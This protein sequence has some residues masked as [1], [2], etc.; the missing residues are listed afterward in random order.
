MRGEFWRALKV[1][2]VTLVALIALVVGRERGLATLSG[3]RML[4][5]SPAQR[6]LCY[7]VDRAHQPEFRLSGAERGLRLVSHKVLGPAGSLGFDPSEN[8]EYALRLSLS[9]ASGREVWSTTVREESRQSKVA[10]FAGGWRLEGAY[11]E[12]RDQELSDARISTIELP[13]SVPVGAKLKV[14]ALNNAKLLLRSYA[15]FGTQRDELRR[16]LVSEPE[17]KLEGLSYRRVRDLNL[18]STR[19]ISEIKAS[20]RM[21]AS[22]R[23]K[24]KGAVVPVFVRPLPR[25][26]QESHLATGM[27][28]GGPW[29]RV[30]LVKGPGELEVEIVQDAPSSR[31]SCPDGTLHVQ[32]L[33][34]QNQAQSQRYALALESTRVGRQRLCRSG[35]VNLKLGAELEDLRLRWEPGDGASRQRAARL[36]VWA[37][38]GQVQLLT[39]E[40]WASDSVPREILDGPPL[41]IEMEKLGPQT[42][43]LLRYLVKA[44]QGDL[45]EL[46][47]SVRRAMGP[48]DHHEEP[49]SVQLSWS[50]VDQQSKVLSTGE[51]SFAAPFDSTSW[52]RTQRAIVPG[53][54]E[55]GEVS[56]MER[57]R[58]KVPRRA[59]WVE[60]R[61]SAKVLVR[62]STRLR[63]SQEV[64]P[65]DEIFARIPLGKMKWMWAPRAIRNWLGLRA[66][67][68]G[69]ADVVDVESQL[70]LKLAPPVRP[71]VGSAVYKTLE[72]AG[73]SRRQDVLESV[74][75]GRQSGGAL[76][77]ELHAQQEYQIQAS[78]SLR[79]PVQLL[80]DMGRP[81]ALSEREACALEVDGQVQ[82]LRCPILRGSQT[83][84]QLE[85]GS[86]QI[87]WRGAPQGARIW[88]NQ[89]ARAMQRSSPVLAFRRRT[90]HELAP[91]ES[92]GLEW[93]EAPERGSRLLVDVYRPLVPGQDAHAQLEAQIALDGAAP[94]QVRGVLLRQDVELRFL[95]DTYSGIFSVYRFLIDVPACKR[96]PEHRL[97]F[98][99]AAEGKIWIRAINRR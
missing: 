61:A 93:T 67:G 63:A 11:L 17:A 53:R 90:L 56:R 3:V 12:G 24:G 42:P 75:K 87:G 98:E 40:G 39:R 18:D 21:V 99:S 73:R 97:D 80:M 72:P 31:E 62:V 96:K 22:D 41:R 27:R 58:A 46:E 88:I 47:I 51:F 8:Y 23:S 25:E 19:E 20:E 15:L 35:R 34:L 60:L 6:S 49:A 33:D 76:W 16:R 69:P 78:V 5:R 50:F 77:F 10:D 2:L 44:G 85:T 43:A 14:T 52:S 79:R 54:V 38:A 13:V 36:R 7:R 66:Q 55:F 81:L 70:H 84:A 4:E 82:A 37:Q 48:L 30:F 89:P 26:I 29:Q 92:L 45:R 83:L 95:G 1:L 91:G 86:H 32:R 74:S 9:D 57:I 71:A 68:L 59:V 94:K 28:I 64:A 65:L